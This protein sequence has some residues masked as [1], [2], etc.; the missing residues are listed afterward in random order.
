[1]ETVTQRLYFL[2]CTLMDSFA[3]SPW[4]MGAH[5]DLPSYTRYVDGWLRFSN[6]TSMLYINGWCRIVV[7]VNLPM[8]VDA[9]S[10]MNVFGTSDSKYY[11]WQSLW[12]EWRRVSHWP[13]NWWA[14][15][16]TLRRIVSEKTPSTLANFGSNWGIKLNQS[17]RPFYVFN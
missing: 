14:F 12:D 9:R 5:A 13:I 16:L 8:R 4:K 11:R 17:R 15:L 2:L 3:P 6:Y 7:A 1:M 10:C